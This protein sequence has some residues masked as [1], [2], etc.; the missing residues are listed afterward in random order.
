MFSKYTNNMATLQR[1]K[2]CSIAAA[3]E[4]TNITQ[5]KIR[6]NKQSPV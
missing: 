3:F 6:Q 1:T 5:N 2:I 4:F